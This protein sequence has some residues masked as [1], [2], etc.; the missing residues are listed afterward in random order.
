MA[1][2]TAIHRLPTDLTFSVVGLLPLSD[3][4]NLRQASRWTGEETFND[5]ANRGYARLSVCVSKA[6]VNSLQKVLA[7]E[8]FASAVRVLNFSFQRYDKMLYKSPIY[9]LTMAER[10]GTVLDG[11]SVPHLVAR[12]PNLE[13]VSLS[14]LSSQSL[15]LQLRPKELEAV[16]CLKPHRIHLTLVNSVLTGRELVSLL[17]ASRGKI[18][19]LDP[20]DIVMKEGQWHYMFETIRS[21]ELHY[22]Q[23]KNIEVQRSFRD[24]F[25]LIEILDEGQRVNKCYR[26]NAV[27]RSWFYSVIRRKWAEK[28][29]WRTVCG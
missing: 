22:F 9:Q 7:S 29:Q 28:R 20:I 27:S 6:F 25:E 8:A 1:S 18:K 10:G 15:K 13:S 4:K 21:L 26:G 17:S 24:S 5:F 19:K 3:L 16:A 11:V 2:P 14:A 23:F 12:L